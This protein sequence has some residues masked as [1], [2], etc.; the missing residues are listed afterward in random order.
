M[1]FD[2]YQEKARS[3]AIY[4]ELGNNLYYPTLGLCSEAGEIAGKV[5]KIMRDDGG[6]CSEEKRES[7]KKECGDVLWYVANIC[8]EL[9]IT[10]DDVARCNVDKL[11]SR[12]Q[13]GKLSGSGDDR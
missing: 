5:K 12:Q 3:T 4:P 10:L 8:C 13:R 7:I 11:A 6:K 9:G 2:E 1:T